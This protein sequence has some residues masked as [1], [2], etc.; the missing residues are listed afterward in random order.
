MRPI[1]QTSRINEL[2]FCSFLVVA[3]L[4]SVQQLVT[5]QL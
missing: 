4:V 3:A 1:L 5:D 2:G